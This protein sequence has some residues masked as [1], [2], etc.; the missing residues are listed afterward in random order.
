MLQW[1]VPSLSY[2]DKWTPD[3]PLLFS[4]SSEFEL[5]FAAKLSNITT[6]LVENLGN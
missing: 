4:N 5:Q 2:V 1:P 3:S 6:K